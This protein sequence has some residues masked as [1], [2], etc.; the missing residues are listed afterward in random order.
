MRNLFALLALIGF[1]GIVLG[2]M[3]ALRGAPGAA[4][5]LGFTFENY[6]G[7]GSVIGGLM[8]VVASLYLRSAW[9]GRD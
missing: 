1:A 7:P 6:G 5:P 2:V 9:R 8:L 4:G 3:T